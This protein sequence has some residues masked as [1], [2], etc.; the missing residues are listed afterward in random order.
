MASVTHRT[1][2]FQRLSR[3]EYGLPLDTH[4]S[5]GEAKWGVEE[6]NVTIG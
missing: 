4:H 6:T 1:P 5:E 2:I 3:Y